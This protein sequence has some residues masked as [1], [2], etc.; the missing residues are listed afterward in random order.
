MIFRL[1][2]A[3]SHLTRSADSSSSNAKVACAYPWNSGVILHLNA[4]MEAT[5]LIARTISTLVALQTVYKM[6]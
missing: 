3:A 2:I 5:K 1:L 6:V 4:W